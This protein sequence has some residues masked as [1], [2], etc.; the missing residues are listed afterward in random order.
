MLKNNFGI[1]RNLLHNIIISS[2]FLLI[3]CDAQINYYNNKIIGLWII[4][5]LYINQVESIDRLKLNMI[6]FESNKTCNIP[7]FDYNDS[8]TAKWNIIVKDSII[9]QIN[10]TNSIFNDDY[11]VSFWTENGY[12]YMQLQSQ[13]C[14]MLCVKAT[15]PFGK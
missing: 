8:D 11:R 10:A 1:P 4:E 15:Y 7:V 2:T 9:L 14:D 13:S 12:E 3:S 6:V 5:N